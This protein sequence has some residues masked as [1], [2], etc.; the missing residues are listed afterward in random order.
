M[1]RQFDAGRASSNGTNQGYPHNEKVATPTA[2]GSMKTGT[3][4]HPF[5]RSTPP[6]TE[7]MKT[8]GEKIAPASGQSTSFLTSP[9]ERSGSK[10]PSPGNPSSQNIHGPH[11]T[12]NEKQN[13]YTNKTFLYLSLAVVILLSVIVVTL[14]VQNDNGSNGSKNVAP[15][16]GDDPEKTR[17]ADGSRPDARPGNNRDLNLQKRISRPD[18]APTLPE[19]ITSFDPPSSTVNDGTIGVS[20]WT[21]TADPDEVV[22]IGGY[23][24]DQAGGVTF[25]VYAESGGDSYRKQVTPFV[26]EPFKASLTLPAD[27]P[28]NGLYLIY[29]TTSGGRGTPALVNHTE[30]WTL[31]PHYRNNPGEKVAVYGRNLTRNHGETSSWVYIKPK[32]KKVLGTWTEV[33]QVNPYRVEFRIPEE[34]DPGTYEVWVHNG[35]GGEYG[36]YPLH[37]TA[38]GH[39]GHS[40][41]N[42][43]KPR[44]WDGPH[45]DVTELGATPDD[46][47]PDDTAIQEA[48]RIA[49]ENRNST[50]Y[51]PEGTYLVEKTVGPLKGPDRSGLR[52]IGNGMENTVIAG[53]NHAPPIPTVEEAGNHIILRDLTFRH[54]L[55]TK[56]GAHEDGRH[57]L[58]CTGGWDASDGLTILDTRIDGPEQ[59]TV[60]MPHQSNV[61]IRGCEI[62]S[63]GQLLMSVQE[64]WLIED[65]DFYAK[66]DA[67]LMMYPKGAYNLSVRNCRGLNLHEDAPAVGRFW[68]STT[69]GNRVDNLYFGNNTTRNLTPREAYHDQN[70]GEQFMWES[71]GSIDQQSPVKVEGNRYH[72]KEELNHE[73]Q[74]DW[75][76]TVLVT[77]GKG[78]G[79]YRLLGNGDSDSNK[80]WSAHPDWTVQP[81]TGSTLS[82]SWSVNRCVFYGNTIDGRP[83]AVN[84]ESHI[85]SSGIQPWGS[86]IEFIV[87]NN[88][89]HEVREGLV[90][91]SFKGN[92]RGP[93]PTYFHLIQDNT[94]DTVRWGIGGDSQVGKKQTSDL[95]GPSTFGV[96][97]RDNVFKNIKK[98]AV[99]WGVGGREGVRAFDMVHFEGNRV[100]DTPT[101]FK[102]GDAE[103]AV[104][105]YGHHGFFDNHLKRGKAPRPGSIGI[106]LFNRERLLREN[107][108][109]LDFE[110]SWKFGE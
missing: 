34:T 51:F 68:T 23:G 15:A 110:N 7:L 35:H 47:Q 17:E 48:V 25:T 61:L 49:N 76:H 77:A 32:G 40:Y 74:V 36:W 66:K 26:R 82:F 10:S 107:N 38:G 3:Y 58:E 37:G 95:P 21:K 109:V 94:F 64:S 79:Q 75:Y 50:I 46:G 44:Q 19:H 9:G 4:R 90:L 78:L 89:F 88:T 43:T 84:S 102:F 100:E 22:V 57:V 41:L 11:T 93:T 60:N 33:T 16:S 99:R 27:L 96:I 104:S 98:K 81:D 71:I 39:T 2:S 52:M 65:T 1:N 101:G 83:R 72:L 80:I 106:H 29:P 18:P 108:T 67:P 70:Q 85:A 86:S 73:K 56:K 14:F 45:I 92:K 62:V 31:L 103:E 13:R 105:S 87:D 54:R 20:S 6:G 28:E 12:S 24:F 59:T 5:F 42:V 91:D 63:G 55:E 97:I 8:F 69:Y 53:T 30:V